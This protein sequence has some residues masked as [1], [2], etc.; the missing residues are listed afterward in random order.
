MIRT[1]DELGPGTR[2]GGCEIKA[3]YA[4][5]LAAA[6]AGLALRLSPCGNPLL[7]F[8]VESMDIDLVEVEGI[9]RNEAR[10]PE[11]GGRSPASSRPPDPR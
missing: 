5:A 3:R 7:D 2:L 8:E 11:A 9:M 10:T 1:V 4:E 6:R